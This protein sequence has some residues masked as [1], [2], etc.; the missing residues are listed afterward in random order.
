MMGK[1]GGLWYYFVYSFLPNDCGNKS[2]FLDFYPFPF[3]FV[4]CVPESTGKLDGEMHSF[5]LIVMLFA[6]HSFSIQAPF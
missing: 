2:V 4:P 3:M 5:Y 6:V 1:G